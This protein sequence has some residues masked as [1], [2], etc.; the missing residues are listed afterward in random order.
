MTFEEAEGMVR[1]GQIADGLTIALLYRARLHGLAAPAA[2]LYAGAKPAGRH[3][4][5]AGV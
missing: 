3:R 1:D 4:A 5:V 2:P